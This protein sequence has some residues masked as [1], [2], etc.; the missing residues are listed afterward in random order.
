[1]MQATALLDSASSTSF[2]T[3]CLAQH[4][5]LHHKNRRVQIP[6]IGGPLH[7]PSSHTVAFGMFGLRRKG[8]RR[9]PYQLWVVET[10]VL[11]KITAPLPAFSVLFD[12]QWK[13]LT[14]LHLAD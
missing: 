14:G 3:E 13:H 4:L 5:R 6:G 8:D 2:I 1:M 11:P 7:T 12:P 10:V 9:S